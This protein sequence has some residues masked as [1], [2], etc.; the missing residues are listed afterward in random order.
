MTYLPLANGDWAYRCTYQ[1]MAS[2]LVVGWQVGTSM[3]EELI[4]SA[5]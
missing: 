1:D 5:W 3:P 4:I 2:K